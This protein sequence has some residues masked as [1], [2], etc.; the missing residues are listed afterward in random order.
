M[1]AKII[2]KTLFWDNRMTDC[3]GIRSVARSMIV[4]VISGVD[5]ISSNMVTIDTD[6]L[7]R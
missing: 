5:S 7:C 1:V 2:K 3:F 6:Q 4:T